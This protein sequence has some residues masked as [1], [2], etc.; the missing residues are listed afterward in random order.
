MRRLARVAVAFAAV[1]ALALSGCAGY[2]DVSFPATAANIQKVDCAKL[3][4][5]RNAFELAH[6]APDG[7]PL[8][9]EL[10][11][12]W[13][14]SSEEAYNAALTEFNTKRDACNAESVKKAPAAPISTL[15][16]SPSTAPTTATPASAS[17]TATPIYCWGTLQ[18]RLSGDDW[19][20]LLKRIDD[21]KDQLDFSSAD[22]VGWTKLNV[23]CRVIV[24][25]DSKLKEARPTDDATRS[26]A[27]KK[28]GGG[29]L[30]SVSVV[31]AEGSVQVAGEARINLSGDSGVKVILP[32]IVNGKSVPSSGVVI[33]QE[34]ASESPYTLLAG[35][36][37]LK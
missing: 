25:F 20:A 16:A 7:S 6:D 19:S 33:S 36:V 15:S 18:K 21:A 35:I 5:V 12:K 27:A 13:K 29:S 2:T 23:D 11:A 26:V 22:V 28:I 1:A 24:A 14:I 17:A 9:S 32:R 4:E 31:Q 10:A 8:H 30:A 3:T 34:D 37:W